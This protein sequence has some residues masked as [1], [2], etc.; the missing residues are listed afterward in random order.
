MIQRAWNYRRGDS[1]STAESQSPAG[2]A[3]S[4][5][6]EFVGETKSN[7]QEALNEN[8]TM[9]GVFDL[10]R[11]RFND[12]LSITAQNPTILTL[13]S[14]CD[15]ELVTVVSA[16]LEITNTPPSDIHRVQDFSTLRY[17]HR[18]MAQPLYCLLYRRHLSITNQHCSIFFP[19]AS[20][21]PHSSSFILFLFPSFIPHYS[22]NQANDTAS[23]ALCTL[24]SAVSLATRS[25]S[26]RM[27]SFAA[28][29]PAN[30]TPPARLPIPPFMAC[31]IWCARR[32]HNCVVIH[33]GTPS[34]RLRSLSSSATCW[35]GVKDTLGAVSGI[36][37]REM[38]I[39][40]LR[41]RS[42][43]FQS[44]TCNSLLGFAGAPKQASV[45]L[46]HLSSLST[47]AI[48]FS[49]EMAHFDLS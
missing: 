31:I 35:T 5:K 16:L 40:V 32:I 3:S 13:A 18:K 19:V 39:G 25:E 42:E 1:D 36:F 45:C 6:A 17:A 44:W 11:T 9:L 8:A 15:T 29:R 23:P 41:L 26:R 22:S 46:S 4:V 7:V 43:I 14:S 24:A 37:V 48:P 27:N 12:F 33:S 49:D 21:L 38:L 34:A 20:S 2:E 28:Q 30:H 10:A 47:A